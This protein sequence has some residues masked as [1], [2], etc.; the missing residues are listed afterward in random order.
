M[1]SVF[2]LDEG[3]HIKGSLRR[4]AFLC[5]LLGDFADLHFHL[6]RLLA[7][8]ANLA[9]LHLDALELY[10]CVGETKNSDFGATSSLCS[11]CSRPHGKERLEGLEIGFAAAWKYINQFVCFGHESWRGI[12]QTIF[13]AH[14]TEKIHDWLL[15]AELAHFVAEDF[16]RPR[17]PLPNSMK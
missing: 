12:W 5:Y 17:M 4:V 6:W 9:L 2:F 13:G 16:K 10:E 7:E 15:H 11:V 8:F 3:L 14:F 1:A